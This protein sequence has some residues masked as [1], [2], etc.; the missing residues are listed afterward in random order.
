M[1]S[2]W[3]APWL[4]LSLPA[5]LAGPPRGAP[6]TESIDENTVGDLDG[7]RVPMGN[8][9]WGSYTLPDGRTAQGDICALALPGGPGVFVGA[10]A[11]VQVGDQRWR[12]VEV[13]RGPPGAVVLVR[14]E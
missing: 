2:L 12:V 6:M 8:M 11:E 13:Q 4:V 9:T 14:V 5:C 10:G 1:M 3:L 7:V